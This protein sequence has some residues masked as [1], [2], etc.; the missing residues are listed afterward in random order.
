MTAPARTWLDD[1]KQVLVQL[2]TALRQPL[3]LLFR[4][5]RL[6]FAGFLFKYLFQNLDLLAQIVNLILHRPQNLCIVP[7]YI[8]H[9]GIQPLQRIRLFHM[10]SDDEYIRFFRCLGK[11]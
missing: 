3:L 4:K 10:P 2:P 11:R 5:L 6:A 1:R 9:N 7:V 8:F